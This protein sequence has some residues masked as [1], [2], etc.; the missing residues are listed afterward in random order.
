[1]LKPN[2]NNEI[3]NKNIDKNINKIKSIDNFENE[4]IKLTKNN[5]LNKIKLKINNS[6]N[7][8]ETMSDYYDS[9]KK[10]DKQLDSV[11]DKVNE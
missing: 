8:S 5:K 11:L 9:A 4:Y 2:S 10:M 1:M 6:N 3:N 7:K